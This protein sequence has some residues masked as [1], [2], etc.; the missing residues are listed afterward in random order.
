M[1]KKK[2]FQNSSFGSELCFLKLDIDFKIPFAIF[3]GKG[4][5]ARKAI[6]SWTVLGLYPGERISADE[7]KKRSLHRMEEDRFV[8]SIHSNELYVFKIFRFHCKIRLTVPF[9]AFTALTV[10]DKGSW[11]FMPMTVVK[12]MLIAVL[13]WSVRIVGLLAHLSLLRRI[14]IKVKS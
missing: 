4:L 14:L 13:V 9:C 2:R 5:F 3:I 6:P 1:V 11:L 10:L 12:R 8:F 7:M